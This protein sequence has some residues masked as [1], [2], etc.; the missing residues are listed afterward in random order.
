M[1]VNANDV[2]EVF[3]INNISGKDQ[4]LVPVT[5]N[6]TTSVTFQIDTGSSANI[7]QLE[8]YIRATNN[9]NRANI[10]PK[11]ITLVM[12]NH[13]KRKALGSARLKVEH[14]GSKHELNFVIVVQ[15]VTPLLGL[16]SCQGMSLIKIMVPGVHTSI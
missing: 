11:D 4:A 1:N 2:K 3:Y 6:D 15:R 13:S 14:N 12:H 7:L 9:F 10:V 8:N 5:L 16:K